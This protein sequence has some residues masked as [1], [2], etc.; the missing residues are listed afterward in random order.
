MLFFVLL[1]WLL[2]GVLAFAPPAFI[3]IYM[4]HKSKAAWPTK[5]DDNYQ[6][7]ISII[8]PTYNEAEIISTNLQTPAA[9][10]TQLI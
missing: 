10:Y 4:K 3:Y 2:F 6:P 9:S 5:I 8:I 1:F 7:K